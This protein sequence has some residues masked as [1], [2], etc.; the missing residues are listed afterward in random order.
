VVAPAAA[1]GGEA[2]L[3]CAERGVPVIAVQNPCLLQVSAV[4]LGLEVLP[5]ASYA[6]AAGLVLALREGIDPVALQRPLPA[7]AELSPDSAVLSAPAGPTAPG[8]G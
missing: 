7:L 5:A 1:L 6:E 3:A 4:A 8:A 2:V